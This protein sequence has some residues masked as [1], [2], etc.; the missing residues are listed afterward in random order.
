[1]LIFR[2]DGTFTITQFTDLHYRNGEAADLQT[3]RLMNAVLDTEKPDL[4]VLTGD[5]IDGFFC[6]N[7]IQSYARAVQPIV[8]RG[9]PWA[10][11]FG[12]HDDE[13]SASRGQLMAS[14]RELPGC[15]ATAGPAD[16]SGVGN[17]TLPIMHGDRIASTLCFL[18]SHAYADK[19]E[20][21]YDWIKQDQI[22]WY[23]KTAEHFKNQNKGQTV[24]SLMFFH[25]PLPEYDDVWNTGKCIGEKHEAVC[26]P[27]FNSGLFAAMK[28]AGNVPGV[29]VGH[30]HVNDYA[31][32]LDGIQLCHGRCTGFSSY[33]RAGFP[34]GARVIRLHAGERAFETWV[35]S[36]QIAG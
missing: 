20:K 9:L 5:V 25:I 26:C 29:F 12:N 15:L 34:R 32:D 19:T 33:G 8:D 24:P 28:S 16:L 23:L 30:D 11:V 1:M 27:R 14:M 22:E 6:Q 21:A 31:G 35:R 3:I 10:A 2:P 17:Y 36:D 18:D 4:V 7:P 13:G